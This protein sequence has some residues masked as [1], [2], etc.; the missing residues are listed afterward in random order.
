[1]FERLNLIGAVTAHVIFISSIITFSSRM[2]FKIGA[3]H[4]VGTPLLLMVIPLGY[5]LFTAPGVNRPFLYYIQVGLM[6]LFIILLFFVDYVFKYDFRQTQWMVISFVV[7]YF[8]GM[9]GMIG[10]ASLAGR[11]WTISAI[12]LFIVAAIL[13]FVQ[14][15][16]TGI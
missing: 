3:G 6:L 12:I 15:A 13:A 2:I 9:G 10:V 8:A 16:I 11:G 5:L 7:F 4:W 1:M 14:R